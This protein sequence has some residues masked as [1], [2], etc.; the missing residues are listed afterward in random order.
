MIMGNA[1]EKGKT[2]LFDHLHR[3]SRES[4]G[5]REYPAAVLKIHEDFTLRIMGSSAAK[6]EI[7]YGRPVQNRVLET[8]TCDILPLWDR[9][10]G[11]FLVL[12]H[13]RNFHNA[14][15]RF[16]FRKVLL[17]IAH[18]QRM[19]YEPKESKIS[20]RQD[21]TMEVASLI[22][23]VKIYSKYYRLKQWPQPITTSKDEALAKAEELIQ[24]LS[25]QDI[26]DYV[27]QQEGPIA[28]PHIDDGE[29]ET[30]FEDHPYSAARTN[31]LLPAAL[32][33][34]KA[35]IASDYNDWKDPSEFPLAVLEWFKGQKDVLFYYGPISNTRDIISVLEK[36][37][38]TKDPYLAKY[39]QLR[40]ILQRLMVLQ[41]SSST[42][43][44]NDQLVYHRIDGSSIDTICSCGETKAIDRLPR[45]VCGQP[46]GYVMRRINHC[47]SQQCK[48]RR[49]YFEP[50]SPDLSGVPD[51]ESCLRRLKKREKDQPF[52]QLIRGSGDGPLRP[53]T[54]ELWCCRCK[55]KTQAT[56]PRANKKKNGYI[57]EAA[58]W[59]YGYV[60]PL[61]VVRDAHCVNC[62]GGGRMVPVDSAI[63]FICR[64][65]LTKFQETFGKYKLTVKA[66]LLDTWPSSSRSPRDADK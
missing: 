51:T 47:K 24:S 66:T 23:G 65:R 56:G 12:I 13:E 16:K 32:D 49:Q 43:T 50:V 36:C 7:A 28:G 39:S 33:A 48:G 54:I 52:H 46:R 40:D 30:W 61:Y 4:K 17:C 27:P 62:I 34:I 22:T 42:K 64:R 19:F 20:I 59:T 15:S 3:R 6:V 9:F 35:S 63:P 10:E 5:L 60:R 29:W 14:D 55:E 58:R 1:F 18:P 41:Q 45:F 53:T 38:T 26:E 8:M 2:L 44:A 21:L 57:D 25:L 11:I 37:E 31:Q